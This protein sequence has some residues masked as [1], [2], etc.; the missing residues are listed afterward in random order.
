MSGES[1]MAVLDRGSP[2]PLWAQLEADLRIRLLSG[3]FDEAF[4]TESELVGHY[5]VSRHTV[6][7]AVGRLTAAGLLERRRGR[8][9]RVTSAG[10]EQPLHSFYSLARTLAD[11]GLGE[12]SEVLVLESGTDPEAA[13]RLGVPPRSRLVRIERLRFAG[14]EPIALDRSWLPAEIARPLLKADLRQGSLYD[15]LAELS[16]VRVAGGAERISP[17]VPE[18]TDRSLL[19]L[20]SG[21]A[22]LAVDRVVHDG[23][24]RPVEWR[25]SLI[26]GDRYAFTA[27]WGT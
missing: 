20:P 6:R 18:R 2:V 13:E 27:A 25:R 10:V 11:Q 24:G 7:E 8:G 26:R 22:A 12:R 16:G 21:E 17:I 23:S 3:E 14:D 5:D 15:A 1:P 19:R 9:T 4:P